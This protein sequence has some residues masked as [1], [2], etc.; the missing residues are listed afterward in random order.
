MISSI[1]HGFACSGERP[2]QRSQC[3][4]LLTEAQR[5]DALHLPRAGQIEKH[6][7]WNS[8]QQVLSV[9]VGF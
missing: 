2:R 1:L 6:L 8:S 9:A 5:S 4:S 3:E 7:L